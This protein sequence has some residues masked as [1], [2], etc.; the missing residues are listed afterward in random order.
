MARAQLLLT[1]ALFAIR[2]NHFESVRMRRYE[3]LRN[4][5]PEGLG[6]LTSIQAPPLRARQS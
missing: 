2:W 3:F 5:K 4:Q 6:P 1:L